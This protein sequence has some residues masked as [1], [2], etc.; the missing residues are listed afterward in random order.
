VAQCLL[1]TD[2][3]DRTNRLVTAKLN[4]L[5][6]GVSNLKK[7]FFK[8][9]YLLLALTATNSLLTCPARLA[10]RASQTSQTLSNL[11]TAYSG[12]RNANLRYLAFAQ[13][14]DDQG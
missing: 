10:A 6:I 9:S 14:A 7:R 3:G 12:E 5:T 2:S 11:Q 1:L 13:K 8:Y 4:D